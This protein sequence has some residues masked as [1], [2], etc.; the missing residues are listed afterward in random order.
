MTDSHTDIKNTE[1][2]RFHDLKNGW[3][4]AEPLGPNISCPLMKAGEVLMYAVNSPKILASDL[5][6]HAT[7][8]ALLIALAKNERLVKIGFAPSLDEAQWVSACAHT[9]VAVQQM[10]ANFFRQER[11]EDFSHQGTM[12]DIV[13]MAALTKS[14]LWMRP[15]RWKGYFMA[16]VV[17]E[18]EIRTVP[19]RT[20]AMRGSMI[21]VDLV[22]MPWELVNPQSVLDGGDQ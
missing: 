6:S 18:G 9:D 3:F 19:G 13:A 8:Q 10:N 21:D 11:F 14:Q 4:A 15:T 1:T 2:V 7:F 5:H 17:E 22:L 12:N 16:M 20:G